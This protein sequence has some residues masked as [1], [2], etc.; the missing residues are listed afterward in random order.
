MPLARRLLASGALAAPGVGIAVEG[1]E[2]VPLAIAGVLVAGAIGLS[3]RSI[4]PQV[5]GRA[6]AW[7]LLT[8]MAIAVVVTPLFGGTVEPSGVL[9]GAAAAA[10]LLLARPGLH[11]AEA[12]AEFAPIR[13]RRL[14]LAGAVASAMNACAAALYATVTYLD[15][16]MRP[17]LGC[18]AVA[19]ALL[20]TT[21]GVVRMRAWGVLLALVTA[22]GALVAMLLGQ[23]EWLTVTSV[24]TALPAILLGLP[25]ALAR[26]RVP[27]EQDVAQA[28]A[29]QAAF[30]PQ[31]DDVGVRVRTLLP[32]VGP[33]DD[34][35]VAVAASSASPRA[36]VAEFDD[37]FADND[38]LA[39]ATAAASLGHEKP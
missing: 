5:L 10:A 2:A 36:R 11:T 18:A 14:F 1:R 4:L 3:R 38:A 12:R 31:V 39:E 23:S 15:G 7:G 17:A 20:V 22:F 26:L 32:S 30:L 6:V 35:A 29:L 33:A 28:P 37:A 25:L 8:P 24:L 34:A 21:I 19:T 13:Y 9:M 16:E 27:S